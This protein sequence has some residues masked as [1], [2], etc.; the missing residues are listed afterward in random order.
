[1]QT[2][3]LGSLRHNQTGST[4]IVSLIILI[5]LMLLGVTAM[6]TSDTQYKMA[7][8]LQFE[9]TAMNNA[10]TAANTAEAT[11][12]AQATIAPGVAAVAATDPFAK[13]EN[14]NNYL[15]E[16]VSTNRVPLASASLNCADPT[17]P[18]PAVYNCLQC[19]NTYLITAK[20]EGAR[21]AKKVIQTYF[22]VPH[23]T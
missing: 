7:A 14:A 23:C 21:G 8:N 6:N 2:N 3:A 11:L 9:S 12:A 1:M 5:L 13:P 16:F 10:E 15:V 19:I 18:D 17:N 22:A 20:G 4:L